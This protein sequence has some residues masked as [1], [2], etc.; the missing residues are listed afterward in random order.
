MTIDYK[1]EDHFCNFPKIMVDRRGRS[2]GPGVRFDQ[3]HTAVLKWISLSSSS[4]RQTPLATC[5]NSLLQSQSATST[6]KLP[7]PLPLFSVSNGPSYASI[8][9]KTKTN[10]QTELPRDPTRPLSK[11]IRFDS[12]LGPAR[13]AY[14]TPKRLTVPVTLAH[15]SRSPLPNIVL[16]LVETP[17]SS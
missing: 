17:L 8:P 9:S 15:S 6:T 16:L 1:F 2:D 4:S 3:S 5:Q 12:W 10:K 14:K 13:L 7:C 11:P